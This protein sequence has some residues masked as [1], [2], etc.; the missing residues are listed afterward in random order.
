MKRLALV[1]HAQADS[2]FAGQSD[3]ERLLTRRGVD[4]AAEMARRL[5]QR[6]LHVSMIL[7][8]SAPRALAT[9]E[10]FARGLKI[11]NDLIQQDD[12]LYTAGPNELLTVLRECNDLHSHILITAHNPG[13]TEFAD[14]LS[15]ERSIDAMTTCAVVTMQLAT[16]RWQDLVWHIGTDVEL[17]YPSRSP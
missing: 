4:D 7:S 2:A 11:S 14:K 8:S 15:S 17:D 13:I 9:A 5:R 1:R 3:F 12:R 16:Q 10:V 6:N